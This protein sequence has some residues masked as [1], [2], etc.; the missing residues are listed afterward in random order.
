MLRKALIAMLISQ[1]L[2]WGISP[3]MAGDFL[4]SDAA[5]Q[6]LMEARGM[7]RLQNSVPALRGALEHVAVGTG[8]DFDG[9]PRVW[10][11]ALLETPRAL[12]EEPGR[13]ADW[14]PL[15]ATEYEGNAVLV[16]VRKR[17][18]SEGAFDARWAYAD[19]SLIRDAWGREITEAEV[20]VGKDPGGNAIWLKV[21][22]AVVVICITTDPEFG[23]EVEGYGVRVRFSG[24][25]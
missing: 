13:F 3:A 10:K 11:L 22:V 5:K 16:S 1:Q 12:T 8:K 18:G 21:L 17:A 9:S 6:S 7:E 25:C 20:Q 19:G 2:I 14:T 24:S 4:T 23:W 15:F